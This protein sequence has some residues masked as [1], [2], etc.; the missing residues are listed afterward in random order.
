[1][2][3]K[4]SRSEK[5]T[6]KKLDKAREQG[7]FASSRHVLPAVQFLVALKVM[8]R[9]FL[10]DAADFAGAWRLPLRLAGTAAQRPAEDLV[11]LIQN[12]VHL[13]TP[14]LYSAAFAIFAVS[15]AAQLLMTSGQLAPQKLAPDFGRLNPFPRLGGMFGSNWTQFVRAALLFPLL[16]A[17]AYWLLKE[18]YDRVRIGVSI[19]LRSVMASSF[20]LVL[21]VLKLSAIA[22]CV[23]GAWDWI[24]EWKKHGEELAM[25]KQEVKD[26]HKESEGNPEV[27]GRMRRLMRQMS[28]NRMMS[29]VPK[30]TM[31]IV[32]PT[33]FAVALQYDHEEMAVPKVVA[34]GIDHMALRI[35]E[36][37][38]QNQVPI[39]ENP[40]LAQSLYKS[41]EIGQEIPAHLYRAVAE[42]LAYVYRVA[43]RRA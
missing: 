35:R 28:K 24:Q 3:D 22:I 21:F 19:P 32:N 23:Y 5:P 42:V 20:A 33:H 25:T 41:V 1:L 29:A 40:P 12:S 4:S 10:Q 15:I 16:A 36:V 39:I 31:V 27:K 17:L 37:A 18:P 30:A 13:F 43:G 11:A 9:Y 6:Q 34:K 7:R 26:E 38:R 14:A 8:E 2:S